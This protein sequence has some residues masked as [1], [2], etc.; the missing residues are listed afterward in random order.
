M[1][2]PPCDFGF[3]SLFGQR[4]NEDNNEGKNTQAESSDVPWVEFERDK[5][6]TVEGDKLQDELITLPHDLTVE[7]RTL[8][9][10]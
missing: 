7:L 10:T 9:E 2:A 3:L 4:N 1:H 8:A 5:A 6:I